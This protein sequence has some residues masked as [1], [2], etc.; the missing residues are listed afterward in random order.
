MTSTSPDPE[1]DFLYGLACVFVVVL[2]TAAV[3]VS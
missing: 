2:I 1:A 3:L